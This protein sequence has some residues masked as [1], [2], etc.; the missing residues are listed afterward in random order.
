MLTR[1]LALNLTCIE[2][3]PETQP[4][5]LPFKIKASALKEQEVC[6]FSVPFVPRCKPYMYRI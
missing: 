1:N 5:S 6:A 2:I 3:Y 4:S